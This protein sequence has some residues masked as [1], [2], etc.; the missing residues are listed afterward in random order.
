MAPSS[1]ILYFKKQAKSLLDHFT[2]RSQPAIQRASA[3]LSSL[4]DFGLM[5][6]QHVIA[7]ESGFA[8]WNDLIAADDVELRLVITMGKHP[9]LNCFGLGL[10]DSGRCLT[11]VERREAL[12]KQRAE[13]RGD[14]LTI[15]WIAD[16]LR[17]HVSPIKTINQRRSSYGLKHLAEKFHPHHYVTNGAFIA[18]A[19]LSDYLFKTNEGPNVYFGMSE[20]SLKLLEDRH[21]MSRSSGYPGLDPLG[22]FPPKTG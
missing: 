12:R 20:R 3:A 17:T 2:Q 21:Q 8:R 11:A 4:D 1:S 18:A 5:K 15:R 16:W 10:Y 22:L 19:I 6:A 14:V 7:V 13:L 9:R